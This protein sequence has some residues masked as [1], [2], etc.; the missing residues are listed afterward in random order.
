MP[1]GVL[2]WKLYNFG[3]AL[4]TYASL[5]GK[6]LEKWRIK[7]NNTLQLIYVNW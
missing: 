5:K 7:R 4:Q 2:T 3:T 6:E 1:I